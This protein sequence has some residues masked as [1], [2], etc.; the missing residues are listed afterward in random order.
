MKKLSKTKARK[1][2]HDKSVHG[3]PLT[4]QQ[5][6]F[7]GA[8]ASANNGKHI[9]IDPLGYWNPQNEGKP[10]IIP[11]NQITMKG[12]NK[13]VLGVADNGK[14][15]VMYPY[16][17][18]N[19]QGAKYVTEYP[20]A[21]NG[22]VI[23]DDLM[24]EWNNYV[25][26][27]GPLKGSPE[28]DNNG[29][30]L[31]KLDEY[32]KSNPNT[33][34]T[35]ESIPTIQNS[36][37]QYREWAIQQHKDKKLNIN[38]SVAPDYSNF[39]PF[40]SEYEKKGKK[41]GDG[42]PGQY[43]TSVLFPYEYINNVQTG[44]AKNKLASF[45]NGGEIPPYQKPSLG[46]GQFLPIKNSSNYAKSI[47]VAEDGHF[48]RKDN[49]NYFLNDIYENL[50]EAQFGSNIPGI[51]ELNLSD[52]GM[53]N[54]IQ[55]Q[56]QLSNILKQPI[57]TKGFN[58]ADLAKQGIPKNI[59]NNP[60]RPVFKEKNKINWANAITTGLGIANYLTPENDPIKSNAP[61]IEDMKYSP[62]DTPSSYGYGSQA[63]AKNG[64]K[65][66]GTKNI[67]QITEM[68][69][70]GELNVHWGGEAEPISYNPVDGQETILFK[71]ASHDNGG[72]GIDFK[73]NPVEV[74]G[75]E[76]AMKD[77]NGNLN[78]LGSLK[79]PGRKHTFQTEGKKIAKEESKLTNILDKG[80]K[81]VNES[82]LNNKF[83][84]L[85]M[86]TGKAL[87]MGATA[88]LKTIS[89]TKQD[90]IA[91][92]NSILDTAKQLNLDPN[93]LSEG[94][95]KKGKESKNA[96]WGASIYSEGI[97]N[98]LLSPSKNNQVNPVVYNY[99]TDLYKKAQKQGKG[100]DVEKFQK[101]Y[102]RLVPEL[103]K[104]I[105][106]SEPLTNYGKTK[107]L[108]SKDLKSNEDQLFGK[109]TVRY[110]EELMKYK[111]TGNKPVINPLIKNNY[112]EPKTYSPQKEKL[113]YKPSVYP[114]ESAAENLKFYQIAPELTALASNRARPVPTF[115]IQGDL[116]QPY[117]VSF[118]GQ[119]NQ[120][121]ST[122]RAMQE[123]L[124]YNPTAMAALAA[125]KYQ[126]DQTS[127]ADEFRT[128]QGIEADVINKNIGITND[129]RNKNLQL[130]ADQWLKQEQA[131]ANTRM[132][133]LNILS[134][135]SSKVGQN[136]REQAQ[137]KLMENMFKYRPDKN[138][139]MQWEGGDA[140]LFTP[141]L[142]TI[143][144]VKTKVTTKDRD[145]IT[146]V[147]TTDKKKLG[148]TISQALKKMGKYNNIY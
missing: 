53:D 13:P 89:N 36:L 4:E 111:P 125:Q 59:P 25:S 136:K 148:G 70:G 24:T 80:T 69:D 91:L 129:I 132:E 84:I 104:N 55:R 1:I 65:L 86:N 52:I 120:N 7:F 62:W 26:W 37:K 10:V 110:G 2:L 46:G 27:L 113:D 98:A 60:Q 142:E 57:Q 64:L 47:P 43:T 40:I 67:E 39:M 146:Q 66:T 128:N 16:Q 101:E 75:G 18:Y 106:S 68:E 95:I 8:I 93:A 23:N 116:Y 97:T 19:F 3:H 29:L 114:M 21:Q 63:I 141:T 130:K 83:D 143:D 105:L 87:M 14:K 28:L 108:T 22:A 49:S 144:E 137:V 71:G 72:I 12:V 103:A 56:S 51:D 33:I 92:Q 145:K 74:Q 96:Q 100:E 31:K 126:A 81:Y 134:S 9:K 85:K 45:Y 82:D 58:L 38:D 90:L 119:R 117:K 6:K 34:L 131:K 112:I 138:W 79:I 54:A 32:K 127:L 77:N 115:G 11:S 121:T 147:T 35:K 5:R 15:M 78:I 48:I 124:G 94:K 88:K 122:F 30:G 107:G 44:F 41:W 73:G 99:L 135:I 102:H 20:L 123:Q 133:N 50:E 76:P 17:D 61:R 42:Y 109:R 118:Q 139:K 140:Q